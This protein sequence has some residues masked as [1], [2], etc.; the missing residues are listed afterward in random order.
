MITL[1]HLNNSRSHRILWLLEELGIDYEIKHYQRDKETMLAP[2]ELKS[3]HPLGKSPVIT[4]G[5]ITIA[6]S[7]AIIEYLIDNYGNHKFK[8]KAGTPEA[9][10]YNYWMHFAE[11][12]AM[13]PLLLTLIFNKIDSAVPLLIKP[14]IKAVTSKV[15]SNFI[16]PNLKNNFAFIESE[17]S[18][19]EWFAGS[20]F[21][22]ADIQMSFPMEAGAVR[23]SNLGP[24]SKEFLEKIHSRPAYRK[25][26]EI[27]GELKL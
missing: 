24:K 9:L 23:T 8:P 13:G 14:I 20:E 26:L 12:S 6:E 16:N 19:T 22:G 11:G 2:P 18:K 10:K 21:S 1:H 25:A 15:R 3:V 5:N 7:A 27:G 17:L 4:D